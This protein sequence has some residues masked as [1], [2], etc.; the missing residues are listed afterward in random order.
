MKSPQPRSRL[1]Y[2]CPV[3]TVKVTDLTRP[4]H[5]DIM[6]KSGI[7]VQIEAKVGGAFDKDRPP[8]ASA[9]PGLQ[10]DFFFRRFRSSAL[11]TSYLRRLP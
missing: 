1:E 4:T 8:W 9:V 3:G 7:I 2:R 6:M 10:S 11:R 5:Y